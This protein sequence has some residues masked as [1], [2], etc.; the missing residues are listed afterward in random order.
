MITL[1]FLTAAW[2]FAKKNWFYLLA[3]AVVL[4]LLI[5]GLQS[6][7]NSDS[8]IQ[9]HENKAQQAED[10]ALKSEGRADAS[11][12]RAEALEPQRVEAARVTE[13]ARR[14]VATGR[15]LLSQRRKEYDE[16]QTGTTGIDRSGS[17]NDRER[18]ILSRLDQLYPE[19]GTVRTRTFNN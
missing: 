18:R 10:A 2:E 8:A 17:L 13:D 12:D 3:S 14:R 5:F 19:F 16:A 7:G 15:V 4:T 6:C 9:S 1:V 11:R